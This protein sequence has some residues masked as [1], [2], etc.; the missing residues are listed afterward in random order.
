MALQFLWSIGPSKT[1]QRQFHISSEVGHKWLHSSAAR[2]VWLLA[3]RSAV[4]TRVGRLEDDAQNPIGAVVALKHPTLGAG[5]DSRLVKVY[6]HR[7]KPRRVLLLGSKNA[8]EK[9]APVAQWIS[10]RRAP[11]DSWQWCR[12]IGM[13]STLSRCQIG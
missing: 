6:L 12:A 1:R 10:R 3:G 5:V 2:S 7:E 13:A 11:F 4:R 9:A 8:N